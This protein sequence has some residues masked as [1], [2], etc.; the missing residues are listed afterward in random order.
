MNFFGYFSSS[1][2][3]ASTGDV[4]EEE[5]TP[6]VKKQ[7]DEQKEEQKEERT[8][9]EIGEILKAN[10]LKAAEDLSNLKVIK[11]SGKFTVYQVPQDEN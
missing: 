4:S 8:L 6:R 3:R 10:L 5:T 7:Q 9:S 11:Q 1:V 2:E